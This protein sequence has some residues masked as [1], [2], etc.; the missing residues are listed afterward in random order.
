MDAHPARH[1]PAAL[2]LQ[3]AAALQV[4]GTALGRLAQRLDA[5]LAARKAKADA[6]QSLAQLS[7]RD[8]RDIGLN[9][10]DVLRG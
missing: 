10:F 2:L 3:V 1:A 8:L 7:D 9:R 4:T 5:R 6:W